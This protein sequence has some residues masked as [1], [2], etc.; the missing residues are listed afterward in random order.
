MFRWYKKFLIL[1]FSFFFW[2]F[3]FL[4]FLYATVFSL[5]ILVA[6]KCIPSFSHFMVILSLFFFLI[7]VSFIP[8]N[9]N[10]GL[11]TGY[12]SIFFCAYIQLVHSTFMIW[13][14]WLG[15]EPFFCFALWSFFFCHLGYYVGVLVQIYP[16]SFFLLVV[17]I[18][19]SLANFLVSFIVFL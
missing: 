13:G 8:R 11:D 7:C 1:L 15:N 5:V 9:W 16:F 4:S 10:G 18:L 6:C 3:Y 17:L 12:N 2:W 14:F 19:S